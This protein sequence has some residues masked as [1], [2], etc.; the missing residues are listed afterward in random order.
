MRI[1]LIAKSNFALKK[2]AGGRGDS[3]TLR[4]TKSEESLTSLHNVEGN[5]SSNLYILH[6]EVGSQ[7]YTVYYL[8]L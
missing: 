8:Y 2:F 6:T 4:S 3:G 1:N 5:Y 7:W